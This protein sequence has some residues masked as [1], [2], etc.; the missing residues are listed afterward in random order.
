MSN[1]TNI[2]AITI[3]NNISNRIFL[4]DSDKL[5]LGVI[6][7]E[8]RRCSSLEFFLYHLAKFYSRSLSPSLSLALSKQ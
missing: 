8:K 7:V 5:S 1:S 6:P 3:T 4:L 2:K